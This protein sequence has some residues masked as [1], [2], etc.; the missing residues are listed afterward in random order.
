MHCHGSGPVE[1]DVVACQGRTWIEVKDVTQ[2]G[3][4]SAV[5]PE[6]RSQLKAIARAARKHSVFWEPPQV[7][8][9]FI[10]DIDA[11]VEAAVVKL[12]VEVWTNKAV[13]LPVSVCRPS[14]KIA[15][16]CLDS[17]TLVAMCSEVNGGDPWSPSIWAWAQA[18][19][20]RRLGV[21]RERDAQGPSDNLNKSAGILAILQDELRG[22]DERLVAQSIHENFETILSTMGGAR[23]KQRWVELKLTIC[24]VADTVSDRIARS[25]GL[26]KSHQ[27][28]LGAADALHAMLYSA[29][30][31]LIRRFETN[32]SATK[33][34]IRLH[35][36]AWLVGE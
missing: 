18:N 6:L 2:F 13:E 21:E 3:L 11:A 22:F 4:E 27:V 23:E 28:S 31:S 32:N 14:L 34:A 9:R 1:I 16:C 8:V 7:V 15:Y 5:W 24:V 12:G 19:E 36:P 10:G 20:Q 25:S 26:K 17:S 33:L 30:A 35:Q 29:N